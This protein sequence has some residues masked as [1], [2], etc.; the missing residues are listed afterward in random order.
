M[1]AGEDRYVIADH[2]LIIL[3]LAVDK[4]LELGAVQWPVVFPEAGHERAAIIESQITLV[5]D[6]LGKRDCFFSEH[7][8]E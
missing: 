5:I 7:L 2:V 1:N 4:L 3:G 6:L 8:L